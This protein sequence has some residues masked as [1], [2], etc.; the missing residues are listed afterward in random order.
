MCTFA[1][2]KL[3]MNVIMKKLFLLVACLFS[4]ALVAVAQQ[5]G[6][7]RTLERP[8]QPSMG[9]QGVTI[10]VLE[11]PNVI[12][13]KKDG[14]FS[15]TIKGKRQG[16]SYTISRVQ[17]KGYT[18]VDKQLRG[19]R[20]AYSSTV[21]VE[22][23]MVADAQLENDKKRIEDR[24]YNRAKKN[25]DEKVA[26]LEKQ[27][28]EKTI[29][30]REYRAKYEE[31]NANYNNYIQM[32]DEMAERYATT[33]YKG[34]SDINRQIL[35]CIENADLERADSLINTKGDF[36]QREQEIANKQELY[37][38][39]QNLTQQLEDDLFA[40]LED[41]IQD[42]YNKYTINVGAY[43][44]DSAAYYLERI[45]RLYPNDVN[46]INKTA[47][48][49]DNYL[50]DYQRALGYYQQGLNLAREHFGEN[51]HRTG[52]FC[53]RIG[54]LLDKLGD[55]DQAL[56]WQ[57][58]ALSI[59]EQEA[60]PDSASISMS[61]TLIGRAYISKQEYDK[62]LEYTLK[63]LEMRE[64]AAEPDSASLAQSYNNL[65]VIYTALGNME[66]A[67]EYHAKA[68][69]LREEYYGKDDTEVAFSCLNLCIVYAEINDIDKAMEYNQRALDI[70]Q[71]VLGPDH[72]YTI[73]LHNTAAELYFKQGSYEMAL[74]R[75]QQSLEGSKHYYGEESYETIK[76]LAKIA[77][78]HRLMGHDDQVK[79]FIQKI[80]EIMGRHKGDESEQ[81]AE[82]CYATGKLFKNDKSY[83]EALHFFEHAQR[84]YQATGI[85]NGTTAA[86]YSHPGH[87]FYEQGLFDKALKCY[88]QAL[89]I[90]KRVLGEQH[91]F[92][93]TCHHYVANAYRQLG[94]NRLAL[95]HDQQALDILEQ[96]P[97]KASYEGMIAEIEESIKKL[98]P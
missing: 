37:Q 6:I 59:Y 49:I 96:T 18:L 81:A 8:G 31:L 92:T 68:L 53:E 51:D 89:D 87:I 38:K 27:L 78:T 1:S 20:F 7:V 54:L 86:A 50:A 11:Y 22:I 19:R 10:N 79:Q 67:L 33:D 65:G 77:I 58:K 66:K 45:V 15:F 43:R 34:L 70:Y 82:I 93:A 72:P 47:G 48:F 41:L 42:Y 23:V 80:D 83:N 35:E 71:K 16:D 69:N 75:Y 32:I 60:E 24:A 3:S 57:H 76:M 21:P 73:S 95:Q 98:K 94:D 55:E 13:S 46:M 85:E 36:D 64:R 9:I 91:P 14:I 40:E 17:K 90:E 63:G 29:S 5:R 2:R 52:Y 12:V 26:V 28:S 25:Y 84:I 62:A 97:D 39:T 56:E 88:Q 4:V 74:D 61:Y 44:N 30:E